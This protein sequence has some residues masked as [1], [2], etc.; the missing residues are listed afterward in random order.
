MTQCLRC[1]PP[2]CR[3][4]CIQCPF[5]IGRGSLSA[6][7]KCLHKCV[8]LGICQRV[9]GSLSKH[10]HAALLSRSISCL[11]QGLPRNAAAA[12]SSGT[13]HSKLRGRM[14]QVSQAVAGLDRP[15][16]SSSPSS[17]Q[18]PAPGTSFSKPSELEAPPVVS[19]SGRDKMLLAWCR[20]KSL[21][22][23]CEIVQ[24]RPGQDGS[25]QPRFLHSF[26]DRLSIPH[27]QLVACLT[28]LSRCVGGAT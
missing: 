10:L 18:P 23:F 2:L 4:A 13:A 15:V 27:A 3:K 8:S 11:M 28:A 25:L 9:L 7:A 24:G 6:L 26:C 14:V 22:E 19:N 20:M 12:G 5:S 16:S 1:A 21:Q 17:F